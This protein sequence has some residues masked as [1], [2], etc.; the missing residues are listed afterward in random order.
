MVKK[1]ADAF[2]RLGARVEEVSIPQHVTAMAIW[3]AIAHE[4]RRRR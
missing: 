4:A 1:G 2:K 3:S